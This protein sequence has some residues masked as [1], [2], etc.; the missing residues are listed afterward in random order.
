[1]IL[2]LLNGGRTE[3]SL[4]ALGVTAACQ[5]FLSELSSVALEGYSRRRGGFRREKYFRRVTSAATAL[6]TIL[7]SLCTFREGRTYKPDSC[8][9][10]AVRT[11]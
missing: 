3:V 8:Y 5:L 9:L 4:M 11:V 10:M 2:V 1:M 6:A 7:N